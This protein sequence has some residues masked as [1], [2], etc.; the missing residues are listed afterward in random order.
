MAAAKA[1]QTEIRA[2]AQDLPSLF[3]ARMRFFHGKNVSDKN[4]HPIT[5]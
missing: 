4:I 2:D 5:P 1:A 3:T